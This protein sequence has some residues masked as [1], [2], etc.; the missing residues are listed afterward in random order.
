MLAQTYAPAL[1]GV[2]GR[3]ISIEC[4]ITNGLPGFVVV[5][6]GDKAVEESRERI[7][8]AIKNSGLII[9]PRRLTLNLA[10]A[11]LPKDGSGYDLGMAMAILAASNQIDP[12]L[13]ANTLF[14]GELGL[15]GS[16]RPVRGAIMAAQ[17]ASSQTQLTQLFVPVDNAAEAGAIEGAKVFAVNNLL[18][19]YR[20][21]IGLQVLSPIKPVP[22]HALKPTT[23]TTVNFNQIYGQTQAKRAVE[24]AAAGNHNLLLTG[25]P[26]TGK[27]LLAKALM[28]IL[29]KPS[30]NEMI[31][32]TKLH[33][34]AGHR[35]SGIIHERPFRAP[36]HTASSVALIGGG[37]KPRPGEI[38]LSH[39]GVLFLD[40]LPEFPRDVIE[41]LRQPLEDGTITVARA[42]GV[43][44]FPA[45][46]MLV[47]TRN[48]CPCGYYGDQQH[49]CDCK[50]GVINQ[51]Q[52][53]LSGP[54]LD[55][56][57]LL[58]DVLRIDHSAIV[59][60]TAAEDT[61]T[62]RQRVELA[63][64]RQAG[65]FGNAPTMAN[66]YMT[67]QQL[68]KY[69]KLNNTIAKIATSAM[70]N[71]G[72]SARS[73]TKTLKVARTIADLEQSDQIQVHHFTEAL[74]YRPRSTRA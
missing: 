60:G 64:Q 18:E 6:L 63:R 29:P 10:P 35:T 34:L 72:L 39:G 65:R 43:M 16:I 7:R 3:L 28:G 58:V 23:A 54:L 61:A 19:L 40:E 14:L 21:L 48:P 62:I 26:G 70:Q 66:A 31:E 53:K 52:R 24:I 46:F 47:A 13:L 37:I 55:R 20:H 50:A 1:F 11:D 12:T 33:N 25:P 51:Y 27:T 8:S 9:P 4:D 36:H 42:A 73:Y 17:I 2:D 71:L 22:L 41:V 30:L 15:D 74:Q 45:R 69:C 38:S 56:I 32:I 57:D 49:T 5:G 67:S 44:T 59:A 68:K